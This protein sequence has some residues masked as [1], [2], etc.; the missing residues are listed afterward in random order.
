MKALTEAG[1]DIT[2]EIL[3]AL[4]EADRLETAMK[5]AE[6]QVE[7]EKRAKLTKKR[8]NKWGDEE[9]EGAGEGGERG[10]EEQSNGSAQAGGETIDETKRSEGRKGWCIGLFAFSLR[11]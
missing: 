11:C 1:G 9:Q 5:E 10:E 8:F 2:P 3:Q 7:R 6:E 4:L